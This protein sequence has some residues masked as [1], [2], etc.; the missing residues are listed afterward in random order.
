MRMFPILIYRIMRGPGVQRVLAYVNFITQIFI[1]T[2][3]QNIPKIFGLCNF[4]PNYFAV[5]ICETNFGQK[6]ALMKEF[7][8]TFATAK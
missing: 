4:W 5:V 3:F 2:A 7:C 6:V 1:I 8:Q